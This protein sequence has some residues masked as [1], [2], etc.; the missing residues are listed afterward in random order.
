MDRFWEYLILIKDYARDYA[1]EN[2]GLK[3]LALLIT[4]VLWWSVASRPVS[5]ITVNNVP[6]ELH[7]LPESLIITLSTETTLAARVSLRGPRDVLDTLRS[8]DLAV[9]A[10]AFVVTVRTALNGPFR[11]G[12]ASSP[13]RSTR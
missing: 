8:S 6:I 5:Q 12:S 2:T 7:N 4:A 10:D 3:V 13:S 1:L 9:I 11:P